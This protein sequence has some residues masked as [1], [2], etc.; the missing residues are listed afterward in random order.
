MVHLLRAS[1]KRGGG[2]ITAIITYRLRNW[3]TECADTCANYTEVEN[4]QAPK[5][6][7]LE[8]YS[9]AIKSSDVKLC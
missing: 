1:I 4:K 8:Q 3:G 5:K 9:S 6:F 7:H 2:G